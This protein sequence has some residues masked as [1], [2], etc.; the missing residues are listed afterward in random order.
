MFLRSSHKADSK[1]KARRVVRLLLSI[2]FAITILAII[3]PLAVMFRKKKAT[4]PKA[5]VLVPLYVYPSPGAWD[6]LFTA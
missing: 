4:P 6:P 1:P 2:V 5:N 3:I